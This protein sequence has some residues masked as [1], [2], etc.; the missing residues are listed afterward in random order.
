VLL[1]CCC[2]DMPPLYILS[3]RHPSYRS[4]HAKDVRAINHPPI[5]PQGLPRETTA[6]KTDTG[7]ITKN[8]DWRDVWA[9]SCN[10]GNQSGASYYIVLLF[11]ISNER[12]KRLILFLFIPCLFNRPTTGCDDH[13][14]D[15][16]HKLDGFRERRNDLLIVG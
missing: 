8:R 1:R 4:L 9:S 15:G 14:V 13:R 10:P 5:R 6:P 3:P 16:F 12:I 7:F 11:L 2:N